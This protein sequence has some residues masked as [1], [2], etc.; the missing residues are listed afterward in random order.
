MKTPI[1]TLHFFWLFITPSLS[2]FLLRSCENDHFPKICIYSDA[3][4]HSFS[5]RRRFHRPPHQI[6][7]R[8][9]NISVNR[10]FLSVFRFFP[11]EFLTSFQLF[12]L[13]NIS[14]QQFCK[15]SL[16]VTE[17]SQLTYLFCQIYILHNIF[18][19]FGSLNRIFI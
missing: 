13:H 7:S 10:H 14:I 16:L 3:Y 17:K 8:L 15:I 18:I 1:H 5:L 12:D 4:W 11:V 6:S 2:F 9:I 19:I